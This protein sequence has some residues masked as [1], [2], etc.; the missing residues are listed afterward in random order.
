[1][2]EGLQRKI[3]YAD[4][5]LIS[6]FAMEKIL[7]FQTWEIPGEHARGSFRLLLAEN[8]TGING[9]NTPIQLCR[10]E[11]AAGALFSGYPEKV[12]IKEGSGYRVADI[13]AVSGTI[14]LDQK[15]CN[16]V[17]QK[18]AQT[19]MG[20]A[21]TVTADTE[22]SACILPGSDMRTGGTLIQY[23]ETDWNFLKRM[24]S[25]LGLPLVP[26]I[27][28][29]YPRFYLGL[30]EG[31]KKELGEILSC[32]MCFDGRYY[33][34]SG[35]CL[36]DRE[37]FICYDVVTRTSL[38][39]GDRVTYE[40]RELLVSRKKTELAGGEVIF[41]Y[42]LAGNGYTWVPWEDNPDYTG[43]SFVGSIV[44][45]Q[46]EQ[47]EV[48]F[49]IDKTAAGGNRYGFAPATGNLMYCMPQ[50]GTKTS[51]YIGNGDEAQGI[52]TGCIR[53]NGST[54]EG[55][56][57]PE[58]KSFRSEHG[59]GM[60]L[61]PQRMG[62]DGGETGKITFEDETGTTIESNGGLV[63]MAK[64]GIR[65][66]SMTGIAMQGMSD[67]MALYAE[68][69]SSL[70]VNGSVDML[71]RRTS[72]AGTV[73]QGYDPF[74]DVPQKGEFDWGGFARNL[75]I[76]LGVA[77]A[78][79]GLALIPG[80]GPIVTGAL[81]GAAIGTFCQT[82]YKANEEWQS[83]NVRSTIET[84]RDVVISAAAGG[85]TG[86]C[87]V[88]FPVTVLF[89]GEIYAGV[90]LTGRAAWAL[91]DSSMNNEKKMAYIFDT[92]QMAV[93]FSIGALIGIIVPGAVARKVASNEAK[94]PVLDETR[95][96]H[97]N[98]N[99]GSPDKVDNLLSGRPELSGSSRDKLLTTVQ[100]SELRK[101]VNELYR[102]GAS[103]GDGG[104]AAILVE[105]FNNGSSTHL[106]KAIERLKQLRNLASSGKLGFNDL[107]VVEALIDD[108]EYAVSLFD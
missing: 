58:K 97:I 27:S 9:M 1:M 72:L 16:R 79:V 55:T 64:E 33:A 73:Y 61:Y 78:C 18:R 36:V 25:Q 94:N 95:N 2:A 82:V 68:G 70:C 62:L 77:I 7:D 92:K 29:Y 71:G 85:F 53:T 49:D 89:S 14:L 3:E 90:S 46:G 51:L 54:C 63:L 57:S 26:D 4:L 80:I 108:L 6:S 35:K 59:K 34:V 43:M 23:Q 38:S 74:E 17:F 101:I 86:A 8:E 32:D 39:L 100:N 41:T 42:R 75:A 83:G 10:K 13:Q 52:A 106:I 87:V 47:V 99:Y 11:N 21:N 12:E 50:K 44:G 107:D 22:H 98:G 24:A 91:G 31:E 93:D 104:T 45:T 40:G 76:G 48:A 67:I 66:E 96:S 84:V 56:G 105:E 19:Y 102:P 60:D 88:A 103:V 15:K 5:K 20:I 28:Y 69:A 81:I 30:P 65:L 37:D